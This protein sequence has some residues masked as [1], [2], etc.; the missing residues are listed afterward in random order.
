MRV[1]LV[2]ANLGASD[3]RLQRHVRELALAIGRV[4]GDAEVFADG[5]AP[6]DLSGYDIVHAHGVRCLPALLAT[7]TRPRFLVVTPHWR[8]DAAPRLSRLLRQASRRLAAAGLEHADAVI[9][10]SRAE[11][12]AVARI[13]PGVKDALHVVPTGIDVEAIRAVA[14][15][16]TRRRVVFAAGRLERGAGIERLIAALP[17]LPED[18]C[19]AIAGTGRARTALGRYAE[20]LAVA[21]RVR[22]LGSPP[23]SER[24]R[25]LKSSAVSATLAKRSL[26]GAAILEAAAAGT[27]IVASDAGAHREAARLAAADVHWVD[28]DASPI[29]LADRLLAAA[30]EGAKRPAAVPTWERVSD[31]ALTV[32]ASLLAEPAPV[33]L[34]RRPRAPLAL[35]AAP[36]T[37]AA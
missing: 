19:L 34:L 7:A 36:E 9:C 30:A 10:A 4:G 16:A 22:F 2:T 28:A 32:Y 8:D 14:P 37:R 31:Q 23:E 26:A 11:A 27:P 21:D 5:A 15:A 24:L 18:F 3:T 35:L 6:P 17:G 12:R 33:A 20:D 29:L 13:A 25:W 1:A